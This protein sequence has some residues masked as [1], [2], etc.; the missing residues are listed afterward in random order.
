MGRSLRMRIPRMR[1]TAS[2][3]TTSAS[4]NLFNT[5]ELLEAVLA[6][7]HC[8]CCL[9]Q[10][11]LVS[12][13]WHSVIAQSKQLDLA[14]RLPKYLDEAWELPEVARNS[15][16]KAMT[17]CRVSLLGESGCGKGVL[18]GKV[19]LCHVVPVYCRGFAVEANRRGQASTMDDRRPENPPDVPR[20][21][22][23]Y[24]TPRSIVEAAWAVIM[25]I[26]AS[27]M[28]IKRVRTNADIRDDNRRLLV[29]PWKLDDNYYRAIHN[30][31]EL[32]SDILIFVYGTIYRRTFESIRET[33]E[34]ATQAQRLAQ[35]GSDLGP[36]P[37]V[38]VLI[39]TMCDLEDRREVSTAE[40]EALA[41]EL[42]N[43]LFYETS[44]TSRASVRHAIAEAG[45]I[46][47]RFWK[48]ERLVHR[49]HP[50]E[51]T[52]APSPPLPRRRRASAATRRRALG[53]RSRPAAAA[54][55]H[56]RSASSVLAGPRKC[57]RSSKT[58]RSR[59]ET[60]GDRAD[61]GNK[62]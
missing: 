12:R 57:S 48:Q 43:G 6:H 19:R 31:W 1:D 33:Y 14:W 20:G 37:Y 17:D 21:P 13:V 38:P 52:G 15:T 10:A 22:N 34:R 56:A 61:I 11:R 7:L 9:R 26:G 4:Q 8:P 49:F 62:P 27:M 24:N 3:F 46:N 18:L 44:G 55:G 54:S 25:P 60:F 39:G 2:R 36:R 5:Y 32:D 16:A 30:K 28:D 29:K 51:A 23:E 50:R 42:N 35:R 58:S 45:R 53:K 40:G 59:N 41:R 47:G